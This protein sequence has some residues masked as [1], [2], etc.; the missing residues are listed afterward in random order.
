LTKVLREQCKIKPD[1]KIIQALTIASSHPSASADANESLL[2]LMRV[3]KPSWVFGNT[4][5]SETLGILYAILSNVN[6][7]VILEEFSE[8]VTKEYKELPE[9]VTKEY[10][11]LPELVTKEYKELPADKNPHYKSGL[12]ILLKTIMQ[13]RNRMIY[14]KPNGLKNQ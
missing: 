13:K 5:A 8:L 11:E 1:A 6:N 14:T 4:V 7:P 3:T 9:L 12:R 10:K 2:F